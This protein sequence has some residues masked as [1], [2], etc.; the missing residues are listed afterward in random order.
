MT[1]PNPHPETGTVTLHRVLQ[2][3][4]ERIYRAFLDPAALC[5]WLPPHG[6]VGQ[7]QRMDAR[8]G[9][10]YAMSFTNIGNGQ[11][12][13]FTGDYT[14]LEPHARI[15]YE[16]R[17]DDPGLPGVMQ[18]EITLTPVFCGTELRAVQSGIADRFEKNRHIDGTKG[19]QSIRRG[20][21][22]HNDRRNG[23]REM[24]PQLHDE[25]ITCP[26]RSQLV[27]GDDGIG[28]ARWEDTARHILTV[29]LHDMDAVAFKRGRESG[30]HTLIIVHDQNG[31]A[32]QSVW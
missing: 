25:T 10:G 30:T 22:R 20:V 7:V 11:T 18:V 32:R 19:G 2:A 27:I 9:G 28:R 15:A 23:P 31:S 1:T 17:F 14:A 5:K 4:P 16:N 3:P 29:R 6:F 12:H 8:V 21:G 13:A 26:D 24:R